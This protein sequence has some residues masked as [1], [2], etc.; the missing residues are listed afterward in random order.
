MRNWH[1]K[2]SLISLIPLIVIAISGFILSLRSL[3]PAIQPPQVRGTPGF[4]I[5][6]LEQIYAKAQSV[7]SA[8]LSSLEKLKS[9]EVRLQTGTVSIR[10]Q[11]GIEIQIDSHS[12]E[13]LS[14][15]KRWT[16][17]LIKIHEGGFLPPLLQYVIFIPIGLLLTF[18][19][20]SG[21]FIFLKTYKRKK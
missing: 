2:I 16:P 1:R 20:I 19:S 7:E 21:L 5:I 3:I 12:G 15:G 4:P 13:I 8:E 14:V 6:P 9:M 18:L 10:A 11:N 17:F